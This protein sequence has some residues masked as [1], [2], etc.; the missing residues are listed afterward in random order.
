MRRSICVIATTIALMT[1]A[2][3]DLFA[4]G[5]KFMRVGRSAR[6]RRYAS[7]HPS[8]ILLRAAVDAIRDQEVRKDPEER[9]PRPIYRPHD[10]GNGDGHQNRQLR[11]CD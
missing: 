4:C 10:S 3:A 6:F 5:D 2:T 7:P 1:S 9:R 8:P 11:T